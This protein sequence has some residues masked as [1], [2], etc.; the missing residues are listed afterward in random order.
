MFL[1]T[2]NNSPFKNATLRTLRPMTNI[3]V[4][5]VDARGEKA[6]AAIHLCTGYLQVPLHVDRNP[7]FDF[8]TP[9][10]L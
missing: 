3:E 9:K 8:M 1:L 10:V 2:V 7:P 6:F 5:V 4:E